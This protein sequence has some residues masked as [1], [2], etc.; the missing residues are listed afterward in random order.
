MIHG[1]DHFRKIQDT[2]SVVL[3]TYTG[4]HMSVWQVAQSFDA[5]QNHHGDMKFRA[6]C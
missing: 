5:A 1:L 6:L 3:H 2:H 4:T